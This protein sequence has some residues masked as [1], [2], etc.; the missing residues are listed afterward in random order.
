M[1]RDWSSDVCSSDLERLRELLECS[2]EVLTSEDENV[3][4]LYTEGVLEFRNVED[5][6]GVR[7]Q[8]A[9]QRKFGEG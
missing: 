5:Y 1:D 7:L 4:A 2:G 9:V 6:F 3:F 8:R